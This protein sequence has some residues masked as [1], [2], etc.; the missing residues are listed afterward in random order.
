[1]KGELVS[2]LSVPSLTEIGQK[3]QG[4]TGCLH[5]LE[6][7]PKIPHKDIHKTFRKKFYLSLNA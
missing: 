2:C 1:M 7:V 5:P 4:A 6:L 3:G